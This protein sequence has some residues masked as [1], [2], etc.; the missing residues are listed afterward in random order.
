MLKSPLAHAAARVVRNVKVPEVAVKLAESNIGSEMAE[1][2]VAFVSVHVSKK[3]TPPEPGVPQAVP[4]S[5][6]AQ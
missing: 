6:N 4:V 5:V 2:A 1:C 3:V